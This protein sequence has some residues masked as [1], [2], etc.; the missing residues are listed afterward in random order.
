VISSPVL[1]LPGAGDGAPHFDLFRE[2]PEDTTRFEVIGYPGWKRYIRDGFSAEVLVAELVLQI[3]TKVPRGPICILGYSIG[4]HF[5]YAAA[6][7]LQAMDREIRGFCAIDTF[8]I[9]SA[10]PAVGWKG[11]ALARGLELLHRRRFGDFALY[12]RSKLWR[13]FF[14]SAGDRLPDLTRS[15]SSTRWFSSACSFDPVFEE[16]LS[17]RLLIQA[18]APWIASL[19]QNPIAL[20]A[21]AILLRTKQTAKDDPAWLR[22][23]PSMNFVEIAGQHLNLFEPDNVG[24]LREAFLTATSDWR[25]GTRSRSAKSSE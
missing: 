6:L 5:G 19:D 11:R 25:A 24:S 23:C 2:G 12:L 4:G 17:L 7:R 20:N 8:M 21:P 10:S 22:R 13:S 1:F 3:V 14:R 9:A 18:A 15:L 16:E